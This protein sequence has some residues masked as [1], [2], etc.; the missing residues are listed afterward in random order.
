MDP[1]P[2]RFGQQHGLVTGTARRLIRNLRHMRER[3]AA[4]AE[5]ADAARALLATARVLPSRRARLA[6]ALERLAATTPPAGAT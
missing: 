2:L 1:L 6:A 5:L 4:V 3:E